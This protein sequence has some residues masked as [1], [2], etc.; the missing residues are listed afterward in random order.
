M[1]Q[2][3][4]LAQFHERLAKFDWYF[5]YSDETRVVNAGEAA[6][7]AL[8]ASANNAGPQYQWLLKGFMDSKFSGAPWGTEKIQLPPA[9]ATLPDLDSLLVDYDNEQRDSQFDPERSEALF[10][11]RWIAFYAEEGVEYPD[12]IRG[13]SALSAAWQAGKSQGNDQHARGRS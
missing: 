1:S 6:L 12:V 9:P 10:K 13:H 4:T 2:K 7:A 8:K 3:P 11:L 5:G